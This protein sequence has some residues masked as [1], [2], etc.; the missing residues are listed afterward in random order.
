[1]G[2][3]IGYFWRCLEQIWKRFFEGFLN[4]KQFKKIGRFRKILEGQK[5]LRDDR[6]RLE[7]FQ[8]RYGNIYQRW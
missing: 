5:N 4:K 7:N 2:K 6:T 8:I 1:M 3:I